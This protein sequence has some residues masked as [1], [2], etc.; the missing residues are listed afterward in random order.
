MD[1]GSSTLEIREYVGLRQEALSGTDSLSQGAWTRSVG[2]V[3]LEAMGDY[4]GSAAS[5]GFLCGMM[6]GEDGVTG[7][8]PQDDGSVAVEAVLE[9]GESYGYES[10]FDWLNLRETRTYSIRRVPMANYFAA[11]G[12]GREG[13]QA[14][15]REDIRAYIGANVGRYLTD[16]AYCIASGALDC[17]FQSYGGTEA[18]LKIITSSDVPMLLEWAGCSMA[19][20]DELAQMGEAQARAALEGA[21]DADRPL[22]Q[23]SPITVAL[24][25]PADAESV[26]IA[27]RNN[28]SSNDTLVAAL[29]I[30]SREE[31]SELVLGQINEHLSETM[32][33][34]GVD[35]ASEGEGSY[36][37]DFGNGT[38]LGS[39]FDEI[40]GLSEGSGGDGPQAEVSVAYSASF[41]DRIV[42]AKAG[43]REIPFEGRS[44]SIGLSE[45]E[46]LPRGELVVVT[47]RQPSPLGAFTWVVVLV[48]IGAAAYLLLYANKK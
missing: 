11:H 18:T 2:T 47:E 46:G 13:M 9:P 17:E 37:M 21:V 48:I 19:N 33:G 44:L 16:E 1:D 3:L 35:T 20:P 32:S 29:A 40:A 28:E 10:S 15:R 23:S 43:G 36:F 34:M 31:V 12:T 30:K 14:A 22:S 39:G 24:P 25:C 5:S 27:Y 45:L 8:I 7:C 26:V 38:L 6:D 4:Y 41:P 42:S